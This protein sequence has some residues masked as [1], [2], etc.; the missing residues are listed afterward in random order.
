MVRLGFIRCLPHDQGSRGDSIC[1]T[2]GGGITVFQGGERGVCQDRDK[3][4]GNDGCGSKVGGHMSRIQSW[5]ETIEAMAS[6]LSKW[7]MKTFSIGGRLT[8]LKSVLGSMPIYHMSIFKVPMK[9]LQR[10]ESIPKRRLGN[11]QALYA[12]NRAL[13]FKMDVAFPFSQL[14]TMATSSKLFM[15]SRKNMQKLDVA[16]KVSSKQLG[17]TS[18]V[19]L[20][21][22]VE[23]DQFDSLKAMVESTSFVNIRDRWIWSLQ[24]SGDFTVASIRKLID[25]F[26]LSDVSSST[27]WIKAV[28][29]KVN[30]LAWKIKLDNLSTRLNISRRGMDIDSILCPTCGKAVESN[31]HIFSTCQIARYIIHLITSWWNIPYMEVSSYEEWLVWILSLRLS[32]KHKRIFEGVCYVTW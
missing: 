22:G 8:L 6:R 29:I 19:N 25:E 30:V 10:M 21:G 15:E 17:F 23:Q 11:F 14:F 28:P 31:R 16:S 18:V 5:N 32:I 12:L 27:R 2:G 7:K 26:T 4:R 9:I 1:G 20:G 24:S 3:G 13:M